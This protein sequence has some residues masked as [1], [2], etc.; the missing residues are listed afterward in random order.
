V[1]VPFWVARTPKPPKTVKSRVKGDTDDFAHLAFRDNVS[2]IACAE[3]KW[4]V[5]EQK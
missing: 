4:N 3:Q 1:L 5:F 2:A